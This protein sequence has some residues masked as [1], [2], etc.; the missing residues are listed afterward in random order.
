[1]CS[2]QRACG[3]SFYN[4][5]LRA[6][7]FILLGSSATHILRASPPSTSLSYFHSSYA[8]SPL[9]DACVKA[10]VNVVNR[11][12]GEEGE[13]ETVERR[14]KSCYVLC[15]SIILS[16]ILLFLH[17]VSLSYPVFVV[18]GSVLTMST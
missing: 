10:V 15:T 1:M 3:A 12:V 16:T 17:F 6:P 9:E 11:V 5:L 13:K 8:Q 2:L 14:I 4:C 18:K 7:G